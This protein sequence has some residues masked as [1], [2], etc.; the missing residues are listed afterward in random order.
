MRGK[1]E[2]KKERKDGRKRKEGKGREEIKA[3]ERKKKE[4]KR[5]EERKRKEK[6]EKRKEKRR[7]EKTRQD[8]TR[9]GKLSS[10]GKSPRE[11]GIWEK[12]EVKGLQPGIL[13]PSW[14][15]PPGDLGL[16]ETCKEEAMECK[17]E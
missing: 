14:L 13:P 4:K 10:P 12:E 17:R 15:R 5:R 2:R 11:P 6:E 7:E 16:Q 9:P 3:K 1:G 8:K